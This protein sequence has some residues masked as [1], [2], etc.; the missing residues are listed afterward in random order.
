MAVA[1][2]GFLF[3]KYA[4]YKNA[5]KQTVAALKD[6]RAVDSQSLHDSLKARQTAETKK[7]VGN[8]K[9]DL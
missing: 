8:L 9:A 4:Q 6:V 5:M 2:I 1:T 7:I 3:N